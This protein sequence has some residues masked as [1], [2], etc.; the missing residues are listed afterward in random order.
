MAH[1]QLLILNQFCHLPIQSR[2]QPRRLAVYSFSQSFVSYRSKMPEGRR[3]HWPTNILVFH[4]PPSFW[5]IE[6]GCWGQLAS[7]WVVWLT[8]SHSRLPLSMWMGLHSPSCAYLVL[9][10]LHWK[11]SFL[12]L[13]SCTGSTPSPLWQVKCCIVLL[14]VSILYSSNRFSL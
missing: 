1:V 8:R 12:C 13:L 5:K 11:K 10:G 2:I 4:V 14:L 9:Q 7:W 6:C 3:I